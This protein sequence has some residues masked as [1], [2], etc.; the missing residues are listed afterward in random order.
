MVYRTEFNHRVAKCQLCVQRNRSW[1]ESLVAPGLHSHIYLQPVPETRNC[2][3]VFCLTLQTNSCDENLNYCIG[4][5][6]Q[7]AKVQAQLF[8]IL[9]LTAQEGESNF[10]LPTLQTL[11]FSVCANVCVCPRPL[12]DL[13]RPFS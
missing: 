5:I 10:C 11:S 1:A 9:T 13:P 12:A 4:L 8:G 2:T 6:E 7:V 3:D